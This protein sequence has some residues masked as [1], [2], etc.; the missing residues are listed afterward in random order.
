MLAN[1][2]SAENIVHQDTYWDKRFLV[3]CVTTF[4]TA[5]ENFFLKNSNTILHLKLSPVNTYI[6][7]WNTKHYL[8]VIVFVQKLK[9]FKYS[10][11]S[12]I[13]SLLFRNVVNQKGFGWQIQNSSD[14]NIIRVSSWKARVVQRCGHYVVLRAFC[15]Y[16]V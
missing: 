12:I 16:F 13:Q 5:L 4:L 3:I 8:P 7:N 9:I 15:N 11:A 14:A 2:D 1:A 6:C 10:R